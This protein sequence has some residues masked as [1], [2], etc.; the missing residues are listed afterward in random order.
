MGHLK[1]VDVARRVRHRAERF[2]AGTPVHHRQ[3]S[4]TA[5]GGFPLGFPADGSAEYRVDGDALRESEETFGD[6]A[7]DNYFPRRAFC[8]ERTKFGD[9]SVKRA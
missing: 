3:Y 1:H 7:T 8:N 6:E 5:C 9:P 4:L 2:P